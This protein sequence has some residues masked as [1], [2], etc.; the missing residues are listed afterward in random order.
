MDNTAAIKALCAAQQ[1]ME[2]VLKK[3]DNPHLKKKYADLSAV[4]EATVPAFNANG[5]AVLQPCGADERGPYVDTVL[6]HETGAVFTSR[7][8][9]V[10]GKNDMQGVGSAQTYARRYG[11]LGMAGV[12]PED[13]DGEGTKA[14]PRRVEDRALAEPDAPPPF[15]PEACE[16]RLRAAWHRFKSRADATDWWKREAAALGML[17]DHAPQRYEALRADLGKLTFPAQPPS[18]D[19]IPGALAE[20]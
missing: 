20:A 8:H 14:P 4:I 10:I 11:L 1:Q 18:V 5:F 9:L 12:A 17:K 2:P 3:A 7:V 16:T 19:M 6:Y 13:D 15:D